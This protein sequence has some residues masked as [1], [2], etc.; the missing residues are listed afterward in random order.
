MEPRS[1]ILELVT[2]PS[3]SADRDAVLA[4]ARTVVAHWQANPDLVRKHFILSEDGATGGGVYLWPSREAAER[5]H[6]AKWRAGVRA[7]TGA[8]PTIRY[9]DLLMVI[10]NEAGTVTEP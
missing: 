7:R 9:F 5:G 4:D 10:D 1:M 8:E 6:D 2:F 3:P